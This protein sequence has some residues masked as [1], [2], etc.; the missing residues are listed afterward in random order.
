M[1]CFLMLYFR[2]IF[3]RDFDG[4]RGQKIV[5]MQINTIEAEGNLAN[6]SPY[7]MKLNQFSTFRIFFERA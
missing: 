3:L 6:D 5:I 7:I 4:I 2:E 1:T